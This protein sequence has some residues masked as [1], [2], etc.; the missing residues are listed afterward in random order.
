MFRHDNHDDQNNN[1]SSSSSSPAQIL[2]SL[3]T[4]SSS[5]TLVLSHLQLS[6]SQ[7]IKTLCFFA[8]QTSDSIANK[9]KLQARKIPG[10]VVSEMTDSLSH[11]KAAARA[12]VV[13]RLLH[14][15]D[16]YEGQNTWF[17][18]IILKTDF[19]LGY[20]A[21]DVL[22]ILDL[23]KQINHL[24]TTSGRQ[25]L[26]VD[27]DKEVEIAKK[28]GRLPVKMFLKGGGG[29]ITED[30][31]KPLCEKDPGL[32]DTIVHWQEAQT[33]YSFNHMNTMKFLA[34]L[35]KLNTA[36]TPLSDIRRFQTELTEAP[37]I[38]RSATLPASFS[39]GRIASQL[40]SP[41]PSPESALE[42]NLVTLTEHE[43]EHD[44]EHEHE[45]DHANEPLIEPSPNSFIP[46][47]G[48]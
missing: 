39:F 48:F 14:D 2:S 9:C 21:L 44:H 42:R 32:F 6:N 19:N 35:N 16:H 36:I 7:Q 31:L 18:E 20:S 24:K 47:R 37:G 1:S 22:S 25:L 41:E 29:K 40:H 26:C 10:F 34:Y 4:T 12:S 15:V 46:Y 17:D 5:T 38:A 13:K 43:H 30:E 45:H 23:K 27:N 33:T 28:A 8:I 11:Q 3:S